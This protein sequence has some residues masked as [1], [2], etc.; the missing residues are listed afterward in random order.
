MVT[1][2]AGRLAPG[3]ELRE[4]D[5]A[6]VK[7]E[8]A[9]SLTAHVPQPGVSGTREAAGTGGGPGCDEVPGPGTPLQP[10]PLVIVTPV[11]PM[12][13]DASSGSWQPSQLVAGP[14]ACVSSWNAGHMAKKGLPVAPHSPCAGE[15][16]AGTCRAPAHPPAPCT[17]FPGQH[18]REKVKPS[19]RGAAPPR[20][21]GSRAGPSR[22]CC[23]GLGPPQ[24]PCVSDPAPG[25]SSRGAVAE[26]VGTPGPSRTGRLGSPPR[27][28]TLLA[29]APRREDP[30][31]SLQPGAR[32]QGHEGMDVAVE[33]KHR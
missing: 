2:G 16:R 32:G 6:T 20:A 17:A 18:L 28:R 22:S 19:R 1:H 15:R 27:L 12:S 3:S 33:H 7:T 21:G 9:W 4:G 25:L 31:A 11:W 13:E 5:T 29:C 30:P 26:H 10:G 14:V 23:P 8:W 24:A